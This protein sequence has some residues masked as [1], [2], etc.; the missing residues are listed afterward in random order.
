MRSENP[1]YMEAFREYNVRHSTTS[2]IQQFY[3]HF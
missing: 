2:A 1:N 3:I